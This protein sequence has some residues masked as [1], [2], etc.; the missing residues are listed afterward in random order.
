MLPATDADILA[1]GR[2]WNHYIRNSS[3]TFTADEKSED[4]LR[5]YIET[6]LSGAVPV[7]VARQQGQGACLGFAA[8]SPFRSG[9]GYAHSLETSVML[10]PEATRQGAGRALMEEVEARARRAG[11]HVL[12]AGISGENSDALAFHT[13]IGF[14]EV[15]RM[16]E[17]GFKFERWLDLVL[18]QKLLTP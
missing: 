17:V 12:V 16:P 9:P 2:V 7:L 4:D 13:C 1:I 3:A 15:G 6:R 18:M 5:I 8:A 14:E 10:A 11:V